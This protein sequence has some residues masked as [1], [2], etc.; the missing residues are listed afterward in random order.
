MAMFLKVMHDGADEFLAQDSVESD[1][2][3]SIFADVT[4]CHFKRGGPGGAPYAGAHL[5]IR[6]PVKTNNVAGFVEV[7]KHIDLGGDAFLMN[8]QGRTISKF[9][10]A[11]YRAGLAQQGQT[12]PNDVQRTTECL[13]NMPYWGAAIIREALHKDGSVSAGVVLSILNRERIAV[14]AAG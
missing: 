5:R 10:L 12:E 2:T 7:E 14:D 8:E 6:E 1:A 4:E 11:G 3:Y 9:K 13:R